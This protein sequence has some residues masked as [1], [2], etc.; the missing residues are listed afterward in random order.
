MPPESPGRRLIAAVNAAWNGRDHAA[1]LDT[2]AADGVIVKPG[3]PVV[4]GHAE[5]DPWLHGRLAAL[6]EFRA[7]FVY[8]ACEGEWLVA[9]YDTHVYG[10]DGGDAHTRGI[11]LFRMAPDGRI[12]VQRQYNYAVPEGRAPMVLEPTPEGDVP[13]G[14]A[15]MA[16]E[17]TPDAAGAAS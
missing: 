2:Y 8:R 9:E 17:P 1:M 7:C 4:R 6:G 13:D 3:H 14:R 12:A 15:P 5:I 16:P 11:E 10:P